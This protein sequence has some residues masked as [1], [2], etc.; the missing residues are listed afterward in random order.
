MFVCSRVTCSPS[1]YRRRHNNPHCL[2]LSF[3]SSLPCFYQLLLNMFRRKSQ[4]SKTTGD[5]V[6]TTP[7]VRTVSLN[8]QH[9]I[10]SSSGAST[11][12]IE[13]SRRSTKKSLFGSKKKNS[14]PSIHQAVVSGNLKRLKSLLKEKKRD[15]N[16]VDRVLKGT[17]LHHA[18]VLG[19]I[20]CLQML[21]DA[22]E[23]EGSQLRTVNL[24]AVNVEGKTPL[25]L[26]KCLF[27]V[28][29]SFYV[30]LVFS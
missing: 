12:S 27:P 7:H 8:S 14:L 29:L 4:S 15:L 5:L 21:L 28:I 6:V 13:S 20:E 16:K 17:A 19:N 25:I 18:A 2:H 3:A 22:S 1:I 23:S 10:V 26:V 9:S 30:T 24:N 11:S